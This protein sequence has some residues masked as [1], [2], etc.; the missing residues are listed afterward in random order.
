MS[1][2]TTSN[3]VQDQEKRLE[4]LKQENDALRREYEYKKSEK[5]AE[6]EIRDKLGLAKEGEQVFVLPNKQTVEVD[7]VSKKVI[8]NWKKWRNLLL[9]KV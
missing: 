8:P 6:G 5:F 2:R 7:T 1:L 9:N 3:E 4:Q